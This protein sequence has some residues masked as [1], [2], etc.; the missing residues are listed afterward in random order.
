MGIWHEKKKRTD[1]SKILNTPLGREWRKLKN[2]K[3]RWR[4]DE[5]R[6]YNFIMCI[7]LFMFF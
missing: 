3:I 2:M 7:I 6:I 1:S 4:E 5:A